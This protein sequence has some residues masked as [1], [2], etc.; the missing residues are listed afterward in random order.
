MLGR[1]LSA[2]PLS[3]GLGRHLALH[4]FGHFAEAVGHRLRSLIAV[5][6]H[7]DAMGSTRP[8][9]GG[10]QASERH[11]FEPYGAE[12]TAA[13]GTLGAWRPTVPGYGTD[14]VRQKFT[15][16]ERDDGHRDH[17]RCSQLHAHQL[18]R[19]TG[20]PLHRDAKGGECQA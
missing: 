17:H 7:V 6:A 4:I 2:P 3:H 13:V 12:L 5:A 16:Q 8:L 15:G 11:D 18:H 1:P 20:P 14:T 9:M 10:T 19:R